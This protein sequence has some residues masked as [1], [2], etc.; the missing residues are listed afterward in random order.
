MIEEDNALLEEDNSLL[1]EVEVFYSALI[2]DDNVPFQKQLALS[3]KIHPQICVIDYADSGEI[4]LEK[5]TAN[6]YDIIF[7]DAMMPGIDGYETC[8]QLRKNPSY[9]NTPII[10]VTGLTSAADEA[11]ATLAGSTSYVT[12]PVQQIPF[13]TLITRVLSILEYQK[14]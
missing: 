5:A 12:K 10:M 2:V 4:A 1:E 13:Q 14:R 8:F 11:K 9:K 6:Q 3:L 7:M